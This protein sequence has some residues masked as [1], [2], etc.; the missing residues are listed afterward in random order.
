MHQLHVINCRM[1]QGIEY[2]PV[3]ETI[4]GQALKAD[5]FVIDLFEFFLMLADLFISRLASLGLGF[6]PG[7]LA[8]RNH[9]FGLQATAPG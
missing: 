9:R 6:Q 2:R 8:A 7:H 1:L 5:E 4:R 3:E